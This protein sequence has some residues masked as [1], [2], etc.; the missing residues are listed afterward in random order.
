M[1]F[2]DYIHNATCKLRGKVFIWRNSIRVYCDG[3]YPRFLW[4]P[5]FCWKLYH[6]HWEMKGFCIT[7]IGRQL[8]FSFGRDNKGLYK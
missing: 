1:R 4:F 8:F 6:P 5:H 7:W 2:R 3:G